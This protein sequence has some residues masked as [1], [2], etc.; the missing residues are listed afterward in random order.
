[1][2]PGSASVPDTN[3]RGQSCERKERSEVSVTRDD[4]PLFVAC[5]VEQYVIVRVL[6]SA[7]EGVD[8]VVACLA[9]QLSNSRRSVLV[10]EELHAVGCSGISR[11]ATAS[12]AKRRIRVLIGERQVWSWACMV[13]RYAVWADC[14]VWTDE[15][16]AG[17]HISGLGG[18]HG[19]SRH[20]A[21]VRVAGANP[22][23]HS[24]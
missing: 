14:A 21:K 23:V 16:A 19:R 9:Q 11:S 5:H 1:M 18:T 17:G 15:W 22:V 6:E 20:V 13:D 4:D 8:S 7:F 10:D 3:P 2:S 24:L 12:A